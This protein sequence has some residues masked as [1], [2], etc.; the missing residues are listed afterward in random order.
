MANTR[1]KK[2]IM[3]S[4]KEHLKNIFKIQSNVTVI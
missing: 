1:F 3:C 2:L 4:K